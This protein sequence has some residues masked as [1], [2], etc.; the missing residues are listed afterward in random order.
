MPQSEG[1]G[2]A[3]PR[4]WPEPWGADEQTGEAEGCV[5]ERCHIFSVA[6]TRAQFRFY[7]VGNAGLWGKLD[8]FRVAHALIPISSD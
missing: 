1:G 7:V 2:R 3:R 5:A 6:E 4:R 8:H